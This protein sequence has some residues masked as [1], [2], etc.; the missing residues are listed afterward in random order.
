MT[1]GV[2]LLL[3]ICFVYIRQ[4]QLD[5]INEAFEFM[6]EDIARSSWLAVKKQYIHSKGAFSRKDLST[7]RR[8]WKR[9]ELVKAHVELLDGNKAKVSTDCKEELQLEV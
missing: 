3:L 7:Y 2:E 9:R 5:G 8:V 1:I 6:T 4:I